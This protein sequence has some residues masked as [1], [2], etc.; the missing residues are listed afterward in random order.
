MISKLR[1]GITRARPEC[2]QAP[3]PQWLLMAESVFSIRLRQA[4]IAGPGDRTESQ[5]LGA[6]ADSQ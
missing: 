5:L 6:D 2:H 4:D 1:G 3:R